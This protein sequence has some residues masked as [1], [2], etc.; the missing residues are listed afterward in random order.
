[1]CTHPI[2]ITRNIPL[3]GTKTYTVPCGKCAECVNKKRSE[4]AALSVHQAQV[5]GDVRFLTLTYRNE[6]C[7]VV[8]YDPQ[9]DSIIG[10]ERGVERW[11]DNGKFFNSAHF[12]KKR[13]LYYTPS[14]CREDVKKWLKQFR[15]AWKR[16]HGEDPKFKYCVFGE[17]GD[18]QGRP[19]FHGLFYGLSPAQVEFL[20]NIWN[21]RFGFVAVAPNVS[22]PLT[23]DDVAAIS[24][25][26]SKYIS[27]GVHQRF[28]ALLPYVEKPRRQSSL[29]F[30]E[31]SD[32]ELK[33]YASFTRAAISSIMMAPA[34]SLDGLVLTNYLALSIDGKRLRLMALL[35]PSPN[36]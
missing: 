15:S 2:T 31:F 20:V 16:L 23:S 12:D 29:D 10:F 25:Y 36:D 34:D 9:I 3:V 35:T 19:H 28:A 7:P 13:K 4:L 27:K 22:K 18:R 5:S 1:M 24:Q 30:G 11:I 33:Q 26:V 32:D 6:T 8:I 14:L 17:Y 21:Q